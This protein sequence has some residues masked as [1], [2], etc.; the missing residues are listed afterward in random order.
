M[1]EPQPVQYELAS[2]TSKQWSGKPAEDLPSMFFGSGVIALVLCLILMIPLSGLRNVGAATLFIAVVSIAL[3]AVSVYGTATS[4]RAF[5]RGL[6]ERVNGTLL[7]LTGNPA[8]QLSV[9]QFRALIE[10]GRRLPLLVNGVPG[11]D[12]GVVRE[13]PA[14]RKPKVTTTAHVVLT[15]TAPDYGIASFDRLLAAARGAGA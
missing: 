13:R 11:L 6:S 5:L 9:Q 3:T 7:E 2:F 15:V 1:A 12:L 8:Q 14:K 10:S 4:E